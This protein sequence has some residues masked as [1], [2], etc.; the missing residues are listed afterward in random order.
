M[1][2]RELT[3]PPAEPLT[4]AEAQAQVSIGSEITATQAA[5]L[6]ALIQVAREYAE[7]YTGRR[8]V[9][10][11]FEM[12]MD[13]WND[14]GDTQ[15]LKALAGA[16]TY[17][18]QSI[19]IPY[20]PLVSVDYI[21]YVDMAGQQQTLDPSV[22]Q[23]DTAAEPG[24]VKPAYLQIWPVVRA[25][26]FNSIRIGFTA[27]YPEVA[28]ASPSD[29]AGNLPAVLKQWMKIRIGGWFENREPIIVGN[30]VTSIPRDF[31]DALLDPLK[32]W[33]EF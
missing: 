5:Y 31:C 32:L 24:K 30:L 25:T 21:K 28:G 20:A 4:L 9:K 8:F 22:Y 26:D 7:H 16:Y 33:S 11:T 23:V 10:R 1:N 6:T 17:G 15:Y 27:G 18:G 3:S 29:Y 14:K 2:L 12:S 19:C 13:G